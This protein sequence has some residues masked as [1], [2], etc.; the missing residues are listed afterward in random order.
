MVRLS[1][2]PQK[3]RVCRLISS[4]TTLQNIPMFKTVF[5]NALDET[6]LL[7]KA[8]ELPDE[9]LR[10]NVMMLGNI[11]VH[12]KGYDYV[13]DLAE[14]VKNANLP[15]QI[16]IA[17]RDDSEGWFANE[18]KVR[19]LGSILLYNGECADPNLF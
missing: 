4:S 6:E 5:P 1:W 13:L 12:F 18:I 7:Q 16:T 19:N 2:T 10:L 14:R 11:R 3:R 17:G 15:V 9:I 8:A